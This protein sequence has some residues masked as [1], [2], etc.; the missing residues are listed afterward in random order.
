M[1]EKTNFGENFSTHKPQSWVQWT[2]FLTGHHSPADRARELF[3]SGK[4]CSLGRKKTSPC[5]FGLPGY[6]YKTTGC[7][8]K[9]LIGLSTIRDV[10]VAWEC[11]N[12]A[13]SVAR[14]P[15]RF[16]HILGYSAKF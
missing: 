10:N 9:V 1:D 8:D 15:A 6:V 16:K 3:K 2:P 11:V 7:F 4:T 5:E 13:E 12:R 14:N